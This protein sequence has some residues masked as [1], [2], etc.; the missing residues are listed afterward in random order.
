MGDISLRT[1]IDKF[2]ANE[3]NATDRKT[4]IDAGWYDWFCKD[5]A[6]RNKTYKLAPKVKQIAASTKVNLDKHY[7]FFKNNCPVDGSLYDDFR[8]CDL[9]TGDVLYTITPRTGHRHEP[10]KYAEVWGRENGFEGPL[11]KGTWKDI[12]QFFEV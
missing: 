8:I 9:E 1:W 7:V 2:N 12:K 3:F 4:Q 6:L 11:V 5:T 10:G